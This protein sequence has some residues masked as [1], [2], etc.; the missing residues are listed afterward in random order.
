VELQRCISTG[1]KVPV[2]RVE[3]VSPEVAAS[4]ARILDRD[5]S[6]FSLL[7]VDPKGKVTLYT[8]VAPE[9]SGYSEFH[10]GAG[11]SSVIRMVTEIEAA[12]ENSLI[13]IEEIENGLHPVATRRMV[14]YLISVARRK[15]CQVIFTTHSNDALAPLPSEGIWASLDGEVIQGKL[16][17]VALR[18]ITGQV[19]AGLGVFVEDEFARRW[20]EFSAR[21]AGDISMDRIAIHAMAGDGAAVKVN[22]Y[23]NLNPLRTFPSLCYIDGDSRQPDDRDNAVYRLP[24]QVPETYVYD[25]VLSRIDDC[26]AKLAVALQLPIEMQGTVTGVVRSVAQTNHDAH[27]LFS[28]VGE[29]LGLISEH[30]VQGAFLAM[31]AQLYPQEVEE[32]VAPI[33]SALTNG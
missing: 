27:L 29:R 21:Y 15:N 24:G 23:H 28:Q 4:V 11:E 22:Q 17:I 26:A 1:F 19:D 5:V 32:I 18:A 10:F 3:S 9:G 31:W 30:V 6:N 33:R 16:D 2:E 8:G 20:I 7:R 14:D 13:L 12:A 25:R